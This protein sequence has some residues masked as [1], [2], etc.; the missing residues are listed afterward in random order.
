MIIAYFLSRVNQVVLCIAATYLT[1]PEKYFKI[2]SEVIKTHR[3]E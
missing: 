1:W 2:E 3:A